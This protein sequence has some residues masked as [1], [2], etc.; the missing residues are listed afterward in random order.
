VSTLD[1]FATG[2]II[3]PNDHRARELCEP[4]QLL[5]RDNSDLRSNL[6]RI[7]DEA[8]GTDTSALWEG[9]FTT[10]FLA[11]LRAFFLIEDRN[12]R[13]LGWSGFRTGEAGGQ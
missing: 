5:G 2:T 10:D 8:F 1:P 13:L 9:K 7:S 4:V 6:V 11:S 12:G 3:L